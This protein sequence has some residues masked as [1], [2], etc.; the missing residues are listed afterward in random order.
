VEK[1][2]CSVK[3]FS[4]LKN[5]LL[6]TI[7]SG[8]F[9]PVILLAGE[10]GGGVGDIAKNITAQFQ[11]LGKLILAVGFLGGIGFV[12]ASIFKFKQHKDSPAQITLGTPIS[13]LVIGALLIFLPSL[14]SPAGTTIFGT[15]AKPGGFTGGGVTTIPGAGS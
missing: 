5:L 3:V 7:I 4:F 1:Q 12:M 8:M 9:Y 2:R 6:I 14:I 15:N 13:M 11:E 10:A